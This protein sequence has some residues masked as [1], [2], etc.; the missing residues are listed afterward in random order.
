METFLE[1]LCTFG[2]YKNKPLLDLVQDENYLTW[3]SITIDEEAMALYRELLKEGVIKERKKHGQVFPVLTLASME[4]IFRIEDNDDNN[5]KSSSHKRK[6]KDTEAKEVQET[7]ELGTPNE[8]VIC[9]EPLSLEKRILFIPCFHAKCCNTC[10]DQILNG[11][12]VLCPICR[13]R[14][15]QTSDL[16]L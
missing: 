7:Q 6:R 12:S 16:Y 8:C 10:A 2:W 5:E 9:Y 11:N 4:C 15:E 1:R 13:A 3:L 14:I